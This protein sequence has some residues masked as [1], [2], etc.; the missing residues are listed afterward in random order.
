MII[1]SICLLFG[2]SQ[3]LKVQEVDKFKHDIQSKISQDKSKS[4][5]NDIESNIK[6]IKPAKPLTLKIKNVLIED[7]IALIFGDVLKYPYVL[8]RSV[9][10]LQKR[11]DIEISNSMKSGSLFPVVVSLL[12]SFG[13]DAEDI[14]GVMLFTVKKSLLP[15]KSGEMGGTGCKR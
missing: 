13:V 14:D 9:E 2:C 7:F 6:K 15:G 3:V 10:Q 11:I 5:I 12:N 1:I 8:D 4:L